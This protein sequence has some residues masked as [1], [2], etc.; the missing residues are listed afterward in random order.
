MA[1]VCTKVYIID[2]FI[3]VGCDKD[4]NVLNYVEMTLLIQIWTKLAFM[5]DFYVLYMF[6]YEC[7]V[8]NWF[9]N[10]KTYDWSEQ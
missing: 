9:V 1:M 7:V 2:E 10:V 4:T 3:H 8:F 5:N 6:V